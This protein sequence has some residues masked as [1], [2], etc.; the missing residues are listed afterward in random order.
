MVFKNEDVQEQT[1]RLRFK[2]ITNTQNSSGDLSF[3]KGVKEV[4][5]KGKVLNPLGEI[6]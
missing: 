2:S 6:Y 1:K 4:K 5:C 3:D